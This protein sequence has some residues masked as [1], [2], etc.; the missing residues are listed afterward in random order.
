ML[1]QRG[2]QF[3]RTLEE[4]AEFDYIGSSGPWV[5]KEKHDLIER[6]K[7]YQRIAWAR[8]TPLRAF[9]QAVARWRC[10]RDFYAWPVEKFLVE[11]LK[12]VPRL[13]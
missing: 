7:F 4:W 3:P 11:R 6:F 2:Y 9:V 8:P 10:A 1:R 12:P 5:T 13:S